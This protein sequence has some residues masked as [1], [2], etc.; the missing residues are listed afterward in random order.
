[1]LK[2]YNWLHP[3]FS[4]LCSGISLLLYVAGIAGVG[5]FTFALGLEGAC[6]SDT[7]CYLYKAGFFAGHVAG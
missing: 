3:A 7:P 1:V 5:A 2:F 6:R 4:A